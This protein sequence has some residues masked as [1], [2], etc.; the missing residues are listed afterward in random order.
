M[1]VPETNPES[2]CIGSSRVAEVGDLDGAQEIPTT[3]RRIRVVSKKRVSLVIICLLVVWLCL[4]VDN[5]Q[6]SALCQYVLVEKLDLV[7]L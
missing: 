2:V 6:R 4:A 1:M 7:R 3:A 5:K